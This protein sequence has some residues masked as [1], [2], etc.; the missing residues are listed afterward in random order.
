MDSSVNCD[1]S[2]AFE[3]GLVAFYSRLFALAL[4]LCR[5]RA[6]AHDLVQD[7]VE[8]GLRR[9]TLFRS[10]DMP[11]RWMC[12]ILRRIFVDDCRNRRRRA[13]LAALEERRGGAAARPRGGRR[14][15]AAPP[16]RPRAP[17]ARRAA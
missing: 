10:G 7:T 8:R 17:R 13:H 14:G 6:D 2:A 11:D 12:T 1:K 5:N 9:R 16:P 3:N 4:R 15:G